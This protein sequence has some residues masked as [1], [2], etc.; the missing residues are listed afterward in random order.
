MNDSIHSTKKLCRKIKG[1]HATP[2]GSTANN[3]SFSASRA[4]VQHVL[5]PFG[6]PEG[7]GGSTSYLSRVGITGDRLPLALGIDPEDDVTAVACQ[8]C[9]TVSNDEIIRDSVVE[10]DLKRTSGGAGGRVDADT[11][12][13]SLESIREIERVSG[14]FDTIH[15][16]WR[17]D[18]RDRL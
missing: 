11:S 7:G 17:D 12:K 1:L 4:K 16:D 6:P 15:T 8:I 10:H 2:C 13:E 9:Y 14:N 5:V 18:A 3:S